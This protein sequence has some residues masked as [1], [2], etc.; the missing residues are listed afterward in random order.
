[1]DVILGF[2][3]GGVG[4]FGWAVLELTSGARPAFRKS[5]SAGHAEGAIHAALANV[6]SN[7]RVAAAEIDSPLYWTPSGDRLAEVAV[8]ASMKARGAPNVGGTVQHPNSLRGACVVQGPATAIILRQRIPNVPITEAHPKALLWALGIATQARQPRDLTYADLDQLV[9]CTY[10]CEHERDAILS[11]WAAHCM[12]RRSS[13]WI[14]LAAAE[15]SPIFMAGPV[16]Y[17]FPVAAS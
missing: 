14:N 17:W 11:A 13:G 9:P 3:P 2:D 1:M 7:D 16:E 8:H 12:V 15:P 4:E 10:A 5:G 6:D